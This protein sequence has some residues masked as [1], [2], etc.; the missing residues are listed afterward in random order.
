MLDLERV[1]ARLPGRRVE[2]FASVDSTMTIASGMARCATGTVVGAEQQTAGIG[3]HGH[4]WHSEAS[5]GLYLSIVLGAVQQKPSPLTPSLM[6]LALGLATQQAI[7]EVSGLAADLRWPNDVLLDGKKCAGILAHT[8][9]HDLGHD[10]GDRMIAGIGIN[11]A[12]G[13]FPPDIAPIATSLLLAGAPLVSREE[14]LVALL[15]AID[16]YVQMNGAAIRDRFARASS[17]AQGRKVRVEMDDREIEGITHGL[18][19][20]G[21]LL[22]K[23]AD[24]QIETILAGGVRPA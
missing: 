7:G 15:L 14:L 5:A 10:E 2:W 19:G 9:S 1:R 3:R 23:T 17:Y 6:M 8:L 4:S 16:D 21:F 20:A 22:V 24:G 12:H 13:S 11:V 18:D